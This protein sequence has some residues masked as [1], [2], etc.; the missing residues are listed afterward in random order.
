MKCKVKGCG[1]TLSV[2][3]KSGKCWHHAV[4]ADK[5]E[6]SE[7]SEIRRMFMDTTDYGVPEE[8]SLNELSVS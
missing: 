5:K 4:D 6:R 8:K 3:N 7:R 1:C 2:Y